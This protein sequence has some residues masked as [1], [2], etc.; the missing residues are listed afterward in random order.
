[1]PLALTRDD[2]IRGCLL[3]G[4]CGDALGAPVEFMRLAE[5][6][7]R[8]GE[9]GIS[10]LGPSAWQITDDTQMTLFTAEGLIRAVQRGRE[11]GIW[12]LPS[13]V[14]D[15]YLRWLAAQGLTSRHPGFSSAPGQSWL[16]GLPAMNA[17]RAPGN[18][19]LSAL[20]S[21][22]MGTIK[23]P[24]NGSKGCGGVMRVSPVGLVFQGRRAFAVGAEC[25]AIT[26]GHPSGYLSAGA[27]AMMV[28]ELMEGAELPAA[29]ATA[30]SEL[31]NW[32]GHEETLAALDAGVGLAK[33]GRP[34]PEDLET[35]GGGWVGEEA[36]AI[37]VCAALA[38]TDLPDGLRLAANHSGDT[39]STAAIAGNLLGT[40]HGVDGIPPEWLEV[41]EIRDAIERLGHELAAAFPASVT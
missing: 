23:E 10:D 3:A 40:L 12:H 17:Q 34:R 15:S 22:R 6:R 13:I 30:R 32:G 29:I 2:R 39:D 5:I 36:L 19:C 24:I 21:D 1:M 27:L 9:N 33:E 31:A 37:A 35:L 11:R 25:A 14:H 16:C 4:A 41:L 20:M 7:A 26:H 18:T 8:Y 28:A 38:A